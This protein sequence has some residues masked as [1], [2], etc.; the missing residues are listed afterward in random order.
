M[1][2]WRLSAHDRL[3]GVGGLYADGRWHRQGVRVIYTAESAAGA[4]LEVR[5]HLE[6]DDEDIP[7]DYVLLEIDLP[8]AVVIE[9]FDSSTLPPDWVSRPDITADAGMAWLTSRRSPA[10]RVPSAILPATW[11]VLLNPAHPALA[12][13]QLVQ[14]RSLDLDQRLFR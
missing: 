7:S 13:M 14:A 10:L 8:Q 6:V 9:P 3:D 5:V 4:L 12:G 1:I 11:N 2:L